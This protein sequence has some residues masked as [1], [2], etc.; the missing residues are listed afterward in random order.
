MLIL[1]H[2]LKIILTFLILTQSAYA[3]S[4]AEVCHSMA[5]EMSSIGIERSASYEAAFQISS[6]FKKGELM[7]YVELE[8]P[9][10]GKRFYTIDFLLSKA[11][12]LRDGRTQTLTFE[13]LK[14][15]PRSQVKMDYIVIPT[16]SDEIDA[17]KVSAVIKMANSMGVRVF[18]ILT[19]EG[20]ENRLLS[21][22]S[23]QTRGQVIDLSS[24][25]NPCAIAS[26]EAK[27]KGNNSSLTSSK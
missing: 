27:V 26:L 18:S 2:A 25:L 6:A 21:Q 23:Q 22:L 1:N 8:T 15:L 19:K 16:E 17:P 7:D 13:M 10:N 5:N 9:K 20:E 14:R 12:G 3:L 24:K 4:G 11:L